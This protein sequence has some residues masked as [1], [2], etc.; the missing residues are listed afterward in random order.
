[1]NYKE[2]IEGTTVNVWYNNLTEI[3]LPSVYRV[4]SKYHGTVVIDDSVPERFL[5]RVVLYGEKE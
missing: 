5:I 4:V 1:M 2:N 3:G